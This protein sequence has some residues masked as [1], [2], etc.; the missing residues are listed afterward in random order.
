M[1]I[2]VVKMFEDLPQIVQ[3]EDGKIFQLNYI[4][5]I[6]RFRCFKELKP[7]EHNGSSYY[8]IDR[9]RYSE[10]RLQAIAKSC[11]KKIDLTKKVIK[12]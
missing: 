10:Y 12:N 5:S 8:R 7:K 9:D 6:G 4:D 1:E 2:I 11:Y 3:S